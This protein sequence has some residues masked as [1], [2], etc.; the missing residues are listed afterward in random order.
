MDPE[1]NYIKT[2]ND[3]LNVIMNRGKLKQYLPTSLV[4]LIYLIKYRSKRVKSLKQT[5][6]VFQDKK[7]IEIGGPSL[8]F[9][10]YVPIYKVIKNLD[11]VN[12]DK[13]TLWNISSEGKKNFSYYR[14][15]KGKQ[16]IKEGTDLK[17]I[18]TN[19][20]DFVLCSHVL[21]H[22]ANPLKAINEWKRIIKEHGHMLIILPNPLKNFDHKRPE[23]KFTHILEDFKNNVLEDDL[24]HLDEILELHD[25]KRDPDAGNFESFKKRSMEN[26][27]NRGLHQHVFSI[28]LIKAILTYA[29]LSIIEKE[30]T[31]TDIIILAQKQLD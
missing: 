17:S 8:R 19:T 30:V 2:L 26:F 29:K 9:G 15:R 3:Q 21:E 6:S 20:Y 12:F 23:T 10:Y 11:G 1:K 14:N 5:I 16:Y 7:G 24:T 18:K 4:H 31:D 22:I 25:I 27:S 28:N 13:K